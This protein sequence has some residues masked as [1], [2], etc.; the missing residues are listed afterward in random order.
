M[1]FGR[2]SLGKWMKPRSAM[3][4]TRPL[5]V[6]TSVQAQPLGVVGIVAPWNFPVNLFVMPALGALAAG[7]RVLF[8]APEAI[9][10]TAILLQELVAQYFSPEE[11][12]VITGG[13][14]TG[15]AFC[16]M[17]FDHLLFTGSVDVG[18]RVQRTAADNL[19]P[20]TLELGGKN[21]AVVGRDAD[22]DTLPAG[23]RA[24]A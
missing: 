6:R 23:S 11:L 13:P 21:P 16:A 17:A 8:K 22:I 20:V 10:R 7:N 19:V 15:A 5:G 18:K 4:V 24:V 14:D 12:T 2:R 3:G 1:P 9:P